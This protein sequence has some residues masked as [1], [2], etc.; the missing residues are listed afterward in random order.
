MAWGYAGRWLSIGWGLALC[1]HVGFRDKNLTVAV[2]LMTA[3][4][5]RWTEAFHENLDESGG[6]DSVDRGL[7][8]I[9]SR[10]HP[11]LSDGDA[12]NAIKNAKYAHGMSQG[13]YFTAWL[14]YVNGAHVKYML[15]VWTV[16][17]LGLWRGK[18][19]RIERELG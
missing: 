8:Q 11:D 2:A 12:Y 5:G 1:H 10:W 16:R 3:E 4:S 19:H 13:R 18:I 15:P 9:N 7:F 6:V 14:A 17:T